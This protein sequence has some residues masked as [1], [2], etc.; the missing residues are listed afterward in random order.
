MTFKKLFNVCALGGLVLTLCAMPSARIAAADPATQPAQKRMP[1][2]LPTSGTYNIDPNH[3]FAYFGARHHVVGLVRGRF[4]KVAGTITASQDPAACS[5]DITI[6]ASSIST[7]NTERD[8]DLRSPDYFDV[9]KFPTMTYHGRGIRHVSGS[10]WTMDG[11]LT[12]HG[13]TKVVPLTFTF[14][15]MDSSVE[16]GNPARASFHGLAATRRAEFGMGNRDNL[17]ELGSSTTPDVQIEID[18]E[19]SAKSSPQ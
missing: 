18:V 7:Q 5:I 9:K 11:S 8:E 14:N 17:F 13:V 19:V 16:P 1:Q 2:T 3:S 12:M 4:D 6:D 10:A 15:G